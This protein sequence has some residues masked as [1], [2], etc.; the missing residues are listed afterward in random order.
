MI[1]AGAAGCRLIGQNLGALAETGGEFATLVP[2]QI[3]KKRIAE[4]YASA[5]N[6]AIDNYWNDEPILQ[7][8][9]QYFNYFYS[10]DR[11]VEQW[12]QVLKNI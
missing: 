11:I 3:D 5:L 2:I 4:K 7:T 9:S 6:Q 1:E 8:Q 12:K 10:W